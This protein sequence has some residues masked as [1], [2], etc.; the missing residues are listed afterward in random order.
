M[1]E[2]KQFVGTWV[3]LNRRLGMSD[4]DSTFSQ[5]ASEKTKKEMGSDMARRIEAEFKK[6]PGWMDTDPDLAWPFGDRVDVRDVAELPTDL[7]GEAVGQLK[8]LIRE[9]QMRPGKDRS[10]GAA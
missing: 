5:I 4:R 8:A 6:P 2:I 9:A 3:A 10:Q 7:L 1:D